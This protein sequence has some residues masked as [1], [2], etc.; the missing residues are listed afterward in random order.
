MTFL[1]I[2]FPLYLFSDSDPQHGF[3]GPALGGLAGVGLA[4]A[5]TWDM[6]D[7]ADKRGKM[8][9]P[10]VDIAMMPTPKLDPSLGA[11]LN[12]MPQGAMLTGFGTF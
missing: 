5:L 9:K 1:P 12:E 10:P 8:F 4:G 6:K 3:I 2:V 7:A 11:G